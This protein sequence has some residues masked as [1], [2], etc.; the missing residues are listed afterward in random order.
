MGWKELGRAIARYVNDKTTENHD[1]D[2]AI[3]SEQDKTQS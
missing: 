1:L 2:M 3:N